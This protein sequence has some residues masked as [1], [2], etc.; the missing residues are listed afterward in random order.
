MHLLPRRRRASALPL[1]A[2]ASALLA[3]GLW[4]ATR[5]DTAAERGPELAGA[6]GRI[7]SGTS[8]AV[9]PEEPV[10]AALE[11]DRIEMRSGPVRL[12]LLQPTDGR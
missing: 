11:P 5:D 3:A 6:E 1:A 4:L 9:P 2:A 7:E 8:H 12:V 10:V